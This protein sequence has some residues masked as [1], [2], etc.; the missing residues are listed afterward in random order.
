MNIDP[1]PDNPDAHIT[2]TEPASVSAEQPL[3]MSQFGDRFSKVFNGLCA[4]A[5]G[6]AGSYMGVSV[7]KVAEK[8]GVENAVG[9]GAV[10]GSAIGLAVGIRQV[11]KNRS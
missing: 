2:Q 4:L 6:V 5:P 11:R 3:I 1:N 10:I 9:V 7:G 8:Y